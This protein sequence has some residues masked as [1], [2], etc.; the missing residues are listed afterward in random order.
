M[1][2]L[3][4]NIIVQVS[5]SAPPVSTANFGTPLW[6]ADGANLAAGFTER[7]RFYNDASEAAADTDLSATEIAAVGAAF[8]Q[9]PHVSSVAV[10]RVDTASF[11]AQQDDVTYAGTT[12]VAADVFNVLIDGR[13]YS[14]TAA[15]S[16][17]PSAIV[18]ALQPLVDADP[19]VTAVANGAVLEITAAVAGAGFTT[20]ANETGSGNVTSSVAT[21][22]PNA[23]PSA[24]L[25]AILAESTDWYGLAAYTRDPLLIEDFA[26]WTEANKRLYIAQTDDANVKSSAADNVLEILGDRSLARTALAWHSANG[27]YL[28]MAWLGLKLAADPDSTTTFWRYATLAGITVDDLTATEIAGIR[29]QNGNVYETFF[30]SAATDP[31]VTVDG[32][33]IDLLITRDWTEAR[34]RE[35]I[36]Q[37]LLDVSNRNSKVPYDDSG[38]QQIVAIVQ[39]VLEDGVDVGHFQ[40]SEDDNENRTPRATAPRA[41]A[42]P[43]ADKTARLLRV[44]FIAVAAG[45]IELVTVT[46]AV[47]VDL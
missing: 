31:G 42:V 26:G 19:R 46:G 32:Q 45:A 44:E 16:E 29:G 3:N 13:L 14:F 10:G 41:A 22:T 37:R 36:A 25:D 27:E 5:S 4:N 33:S 39:G 21:T 40:E 23:G 34:M 28:D 35:R 12:A 24:D 8:A 11:V 38:I 17:T 30:G 9:N 7:I 2:N 18:T 1:G 43:T 15:G 20:S 47:V 6:A